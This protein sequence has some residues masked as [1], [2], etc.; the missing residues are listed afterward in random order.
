MS[1]YGPAIVD[2]SRYLQDKSSPS[3]LKD[4]EEAAE[5]LKKTSCLIVK[6][7]RVT[8][9][10][11]Q[12]FLDM[13]ERYYDQS[14]EDKMKDVH[15]ELSYQ[16]GATPEFV[17]VPRDHLDRIKSLDK[18]NSAHIPSIPNGD[19]FGELEIVLRVQ[20]FLSSMLLL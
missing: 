7:P 14:L 17:E 12:I 18:N 11:N 13:M 15:P 8:E 6:D 19:T 3:A 5:T 1:N 4:C 16:L 2:I 20:S 10:D 9:Q